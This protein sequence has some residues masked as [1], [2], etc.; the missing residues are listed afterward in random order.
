MNGWISLRIAVVLLATG[1]TGCGVGGGSE[2]GG[3]NTG[4]PQGSSSGGAEPGVDGGGTS[5]GGENSAGSGSGSDTGTGT[6]TAPGTGGGTVELPNRVSVNLP[7]DCEA[8]QNGFTG[9]WVSEFCGTNVE[10]TM[11]YRTVL[12]FHPDGILKLIRVEWGVA[13]CPSATEPGV[14]ASATQPAYVFGGE[15]ATAT[16]GEVGHLLD[17]DGGNT[18]TVVGELPQLR[19]YGVQRLCVHVGH[20][21]GQQGIIAGVQ[22]AAEGPYPVDNT[23]CLQRHLKE[24]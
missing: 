19:Q 18:R 16:E 12:W 1:M 11:S 24:E 9:C 14:T 7:F 22:R 17:L 3:G 20:Y 23:D 15:V 8:D 6:G 5:S 21:D 2:D 10:S 13:G 4:A